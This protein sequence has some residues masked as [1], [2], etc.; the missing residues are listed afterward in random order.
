[1][2]RYHTDPPVAKTKSRSHP[3]TYLDS[4]AIFIRLV[5]PTTALETYRVPGHGAPSELIQEVISTNF[6]A[7]PAETSRLAKPSTK[8]SNVGADLV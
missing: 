8:D 3:N 5:R 6:P 1:M 4:N 2:I 7:D